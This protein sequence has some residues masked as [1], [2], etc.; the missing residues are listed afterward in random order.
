MLIFP[1]TNNLLNLIKFQYFKDSLQYHTKPKL[2]EII[3]LPA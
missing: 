2:H 3:H 1:F